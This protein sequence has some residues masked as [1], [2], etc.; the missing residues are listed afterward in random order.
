MK[1]SFDTEAGIDKVNKEL[2]I[3]RYV[4]SQAVVEEALNN[5]SKAEKIK[6]ERGIAYAKLNISAGDFLQ[7]K[8]NPALKNLTDA[9][10]W[11]ASNPSEQG[12][13]RA[14]NL[15]SNLYEGLGEYEKALSNSLQSLKLAGDAGDH[16]NEA[17]ACSQLGLI[18]SRLGNF[19]KSLEY[20]NKALKIREDMGAE[21]AVASSFNRIG[22]VLRQMKRYDESLEYYNKSLE[23]RL[24]NNQVG[25]IPW[26]MLGIAST[27]EEMKR[28]PEALD[29]YNQGMIACDKRCTL[30][31]LIGSGRIYSLLGN[32]SL[33]E[34]SLKKSLGMAR[35]LK[36]PSL[37]AEA[38][39]GLANHYETTGNA[40]KAL[41]NHKLYHKTKETVQSDEAQ[42]RLRNVEISYAV[43]K[44]E[45]EKEIYRLKNV[46]LK[47]AYDLI[48]EINKEITAGINYAS[49]IQ[50]A[51]LSNPSQIRGLTN[52]YFI[53]YLPKEIVS[54]DFY[55][56]NRSGNKLII[57]A[58]DCTGHGVP[59]A[60][61]S[62]LGIS[63]L[64]EIVNFRGIEESGKILDEL[65][66]EV[67]RALKQEGKRED[68]KDGMDISICVI[69][70]DKKTLQY[71]GANNNLYLVRKNELIEYSADRMPIGAADI[72]DINFKS[73]DIDIYP[74]DVIY[75]FSDGYADQSGGQN[76]K[77]YKYSVLKTFLLSIHNLPM[78]KQKQML[79]KGFYDWKGINPQRDDILIMGLKI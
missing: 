21:N 43:E 3:K 67:R 33:A 16:E 65:R 2:W 32:A 59:G 60:L 72:G 54:G 49:R 39:L 66:K 9:L 62:M 69:D 47:Q 13:Y 31:C 12:F 25:S 1:K 17:E 52:K 36:A 75:M 61:M 46:E 6:Y 73:T 10:R 29:F 28:H 68:V 64:E 50:R 44:S 70:R 26:T 74:G 71:S 8:N 45:Q 57:A 55:W 63:F 11:F 4:N 7:S 41:K 35:E 42:N 27:Y 76:R 77:K 5:L 24:N 34:E 18:Y 38:Y 48:D 37:V 78:Q 56:F 22:M 14:L 53:L 40:I 23:I 19:P 51:M 20:F 15:K 79:E 30:Q 58:G